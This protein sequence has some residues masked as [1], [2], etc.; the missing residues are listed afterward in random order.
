MKK[1][2]RGFTLL[3]LLIAVVIFSIVAVVLYSSFHTGIR[4]LRRSES[5]MEFHQD[6]RLVTEELSLDLRNTLLASL[7]EEPIETPVEEEEEERAVYY[8]IGEAKKF[9]FV[10]LKGRDICNVT[11]FLKGG[12][13]GGNLMRITQYQGRGFATR[14]D[15]TEALLS[16]IG[17]M[18]VSYSFEGEDEDSP[19]IWR[20]EWDQEER[21]PLGVKINLKLKGLGSLTEFT[22]TVYISVGALGVME[23]S[24]I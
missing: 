21:V 14:P 24:E 3:E 19:P 13:V 4:I 10:T 16:G 17:D 23:E 15:E 1:I 9:S 20:N 6:L 8:F 22:K 18:E 12:E 2:R 11:Y 7:Y 5:A